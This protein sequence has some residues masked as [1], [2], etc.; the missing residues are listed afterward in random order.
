MADNFYTHSLKHTLAEGWTLLLTHRRQLSIVA[1]QHQT[2]T[3]RAIDVG[4]EIVEHIAGTKCSYK[5]I[6]A[7]YHRRLIDNEHCVFVLVLV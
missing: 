4:D 6:L 3:T 5:A 2:T 1:H 7:G